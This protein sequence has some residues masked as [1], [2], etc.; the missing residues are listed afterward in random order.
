[1]KFSCEKVSIAGLY[2]RTGADQT[3]Y[4]ICYLIL[5]QKTMNKHPSCDHDNCHSWFHEHTELVILA[6]E[7][8]PCE[9]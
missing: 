8:L 5:K 6:Q 7:D 3:D 1:M 9:N 4:S 2:Y